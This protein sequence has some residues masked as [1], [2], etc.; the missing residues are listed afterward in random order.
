MFSFY[1]I[2]KGALEKIDYFRRR[3]LWQEDQGIRKYHLV[4]WPIVCSP[5]DMGGLG[6]SDL[7]TMN[8]ALLGKWLW[9]LENTDALWQKL[10]REKYL[11]KKLLTAQK[12]KQGDSHFWHGLMEIKENFISVKYP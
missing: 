6:I 7:E 3:Y 11:K 1:R 8:K 5:R 4:Q 2:P 9:R 10:L 12:I